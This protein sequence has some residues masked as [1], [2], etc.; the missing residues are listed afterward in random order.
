[1]D[2]SIEFVISGYADGGR[3]H[4]R[5]G[6]S[7]ADWKM[8]QGRRVA[9]RG[10]HCSGGRDSA[11]RSDM[12]VLANVYLHFSLDLWFERKFNHSAGVRRTWCDSLMTSWELPVSGGCAEVS[13]PIAGT[14]RAVQ[15]G[16]GRGQD[17]A[18][19]LWSFR[20]RHA[21]QTRPETGDCR[22]SRLQARLWGGSSWALHGNSYPQQ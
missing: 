17:S 21:G 15:S 18:A 22:V 14:L 10:L 4:R 3:P 19:A 5:P 16:I 8:A 9:R 12:P 2:S 20:C 6:H 1:M 11:R 13:A 7:S